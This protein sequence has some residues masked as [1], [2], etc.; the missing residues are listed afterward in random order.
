MRNRPIKLETHELVEL[1][2]GFV[3][4]LVSFVWLFAGRPVIVCV[5]GMAAGA[6]I[7]SLGVGAT[8]RDRPALPSVHLQLDSVSIGL[9]G[10]TTLAA[11]FAGLAGTTLFY[12]VAL[13]VEIGLR[14]GT[15]YATQPRRH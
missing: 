8:G 6:L 15:S 7:L 11:L 9:L 5:L 13:G 12:L 3:V 14:A 1:V 2:A 10:L 4:L